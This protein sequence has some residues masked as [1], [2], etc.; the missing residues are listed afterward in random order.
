MFENYLQLA[1]IALVVCPSYVVFGYNQAGLGGLLNFPSWTEQFPAIDTA[2]TVGHEKS[3]HS[4]VQGAIV[5][6][7]TLGALFGSLSCV[8]I[9]DYLGR[10]RTIFLG[11]CVSI[12]GQVL[13]LSAHSLLQFTIGRVIIGVGVGLL[14]ATVPVWLSECSSADKRGRNVV[15][16]GLFIALGFAISEWVNF[17]FY[18]IQDS[19]ASW[20]GSLSVPL[21]F[22]SVIICS[23]P[24]LPESPR[25][26]VRKNEITAAKQALAA[27]KQKPVDSD[28]IIAEVAGIEM[29]LED[30]KEVSLKDLF[31]M[32][33]DK[34]FYRFALCMLLQFFQQ[35]S[36]GTLISVYIPIIFEKNLNLGPSTGK[37]LASAAMTWKF[38]SCFVC[39]FSID[40]IGRRVAF[41]ISGA[42]MSLCMT[43][44]AVSNSFGSDN[45]SASIASGFFIFLFNFFLPIG[46][47]GANFLYTTEVAPASL[48]VAMQAISTANHWLWMFAVAMMTPVA[49]NDIGYRYYIVY[50]VIAGMIA[51]TVY[52][53]YPETTGQNLEDLDLIFREAPS[54]RDVVRLSK[55]PRVRSESTHT[56]DYKAQLE[57]IDLVEC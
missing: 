29:S 25:W 48:R 46:F 17:G 23:I 52:F 5:A 31:V 26:L 28:E 45:H 57:H 18:H 3:H 55:K 34:L 47:L 13:E 1:Q 11:A 39:F 50:A 53:F 44:M 22:S 20:R 40:R 38:L 21:L 41:M 37:I 27:L 7:F 10:K 12:V 15:L 43:A 42:G 14:S 36:G 33:E 16:T 30:H 19:A 24:F 6:S 49:F 8:W 32:G 56:S 9:G 51:P 35:M 54:I 2:N 4:T